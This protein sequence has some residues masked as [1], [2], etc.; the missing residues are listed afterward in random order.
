[1]IRNYLLIT[2]RSLMKNKGYAAINIFGLAFGLASCLIIFFFVRMELSVD[3]FHE[4]HD[5]IFRITNTFE[6]SSGTIFWARTPPALAPAIKSN[7][8]SVQ[9]VTRLRYA[10]DHIYTYGDKIF[11]QGNVFYAD[12]AFLQIF[13]FKLKSGSRK[14]ALKDPNSIVLTEAMAARFF[15]NDDPMGKLINFDNQ[16]P[17]QVTGILEDL[18]VN[19]HITFDML[20]S[21]NT[22]RV[23]DGY[24]ADL[25]SWSW[26][27]F[28]T[29]ALLSDNADLAATN[30]Q[31]LKLYKEHFNSANIDAK[32][33]M[34]SLL[35]IYL[36][37][38]KYT[39]IGESI[40]TGNKTTIYG[41][42]VVALLI[43]V[44]AGFNFMNLST[45]LSLGRGKEI[46][47]RKTMG[48]A[49]GRIIAQFLVESQVVSF[50]SLFVALILTVITQ[51]YFETQLGVV[52][53]PLSEYLFL[54]PLF[55]LATMFFGLLAGSY[56]SFILS[57]FSPIAALTGNLKAGKSGAIFRNSLMVF[58]FIISVLLIAGSMVIVS[59]INFIKNKNLGFEQENILQI[60]VLREDMAKHYHTLKNKFQ[61]HAQC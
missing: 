26:A 45:A 44:M 12:S 36:D 9:K 59:Q 3:K 37:S 49:K 35:S 23:P 47:I 17:L 39:N 61:Q 54:L 27:G 2:F 22:F 16:L 14:T 42:S 19:T 8:S 5:R 25:N 20:I 6:R 13:D 28:H 58:Q 30:D 33:E 40:R 48:A 57:S 4:K 11:S 55:F 56:P 43:L 60:K 50:L 52:L 21:F 53:P 31:I 24:L 32:T 38:E 18:P 7:I 15:G 34:Q 51:S 1:M 29:Y 10:D 46:G 41:L